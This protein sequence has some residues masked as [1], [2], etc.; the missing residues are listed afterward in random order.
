MIRHIVMWNLKDEAMG[1]PKDINATLV[2]IKLEGLVG[3]IAGLRCMEV[4]KN[5]M[6]DGYDICLYSEMDDLDALDFYINHPLH[7]NIQLFVQSVVSQRVACDMN[8]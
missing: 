2:K 6:D 5:I 3:R 7:R 1:N 4:N 8:I